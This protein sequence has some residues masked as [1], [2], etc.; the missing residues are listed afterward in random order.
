MCIYF[1]F[2]AVNITLIDI[3]LCTLLHLAGYF[4]NLFLEEKIVEEQFTYRIVKQRIIS[5]HMR[6]STGCRTLP[7]GGGWR[8]M[9]M[10]WKH[11]LEDDD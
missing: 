6:V 4:F 7:G 2:S 9:Q 5:D 1:R 11:L 3:L 10:V 8:W